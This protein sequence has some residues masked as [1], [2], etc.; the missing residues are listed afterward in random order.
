M[1]VHT[2]IMVS[3]CFRNRQPW[4]ACEVQFPVGVGTEAFG[5]QMEAIIINFAA[6]LGKNQT[7]NIVIANIEC[8]RNA[9]LAR[10]E[11]IN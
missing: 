11:E 1:I 5:D 6:W 3:Y 8:M 7:G 10:S 2:Q 9:N 4:S